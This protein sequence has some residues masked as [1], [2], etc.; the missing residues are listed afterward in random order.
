V[1]K[2]VL[3]GAFAQHLMYAPVLSG[4]VFGAMAERGVE[5]HCIAKKMV[6]H[7]TQAGQDL[8]AR[9]QYVSKLK[10]LF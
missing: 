10:P 3:T 6:T 2:N 4:G 5:D 1:L 8:I 9:R 7:S